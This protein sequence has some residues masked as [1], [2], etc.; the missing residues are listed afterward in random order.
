[1]FMLCHTFIIFH[2]K[3]KLKTV[4]NLLLQFKKMP[5]EML[6]KPLIG[7]VYAQLFKAVFLQ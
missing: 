5:I 7:I 6:L 2:I 1:M 4:T 3:L